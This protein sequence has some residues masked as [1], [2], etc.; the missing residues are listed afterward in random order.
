LCSIVDG[1][2]AHLDRNGVIRPNPYSRE[3]KREWHRMLIHI[4]EERSHKIESAAYRFKE[5]FGHWPEDR[6]VTPLEPS[7]EVRAWARHCAIR[8]AKS[9]ARDAGP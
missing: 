3:Q 7:P 6:Y 1:D 4:A 8:Y 2:L 5:K 9:K